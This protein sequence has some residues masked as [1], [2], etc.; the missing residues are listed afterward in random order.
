MPLSDVACRGGKPGAKPYRKTDGGR[1]S[2]LIQPSGSKLWQWSYR[3][4]GRQKTLSIGAYPLI[5]LADAR[6][7][8]DEGRRRLLGRGGP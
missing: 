3:H 4:G 8:R 5:G 6:A 2:L 7:T 1:L